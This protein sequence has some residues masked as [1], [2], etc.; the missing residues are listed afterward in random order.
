MV[1]W[2]DIDFNDAEKFIDVEQAGRFYES[3]YEIY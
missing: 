3:D 2:Y 1:S